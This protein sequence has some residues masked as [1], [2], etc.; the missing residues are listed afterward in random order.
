M[1]CRLPHAS[2]RRI[3]NLSDLPPANDTSILS[4]EF[5]PVAITTSPPYSL[6]TRSV[7]SGFNVYT[8]AVGSPTL[9]RMLMFQ[10]DDVADHIEAS[11]AHFDR[12]Q[13]LH[14]V[15][16]SPYARWYRSQQATCRAQILPMSPLSRCSA[17]LSLRCVFFHSPLVC[18]AT[19]FAC[20][21][22]RS[23]FEEQPSIPARFS[24]SVLWKSPICSPATGS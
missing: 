3:G 9:M 2:V 23:S 13:P 7:P 22:C 24:L 20:A 19:T 17:S 4:T 5:Q 11:A 14:M 8:L 12:S 16:L 15:Y 21:A 6:W 10:N 1:T 18:A